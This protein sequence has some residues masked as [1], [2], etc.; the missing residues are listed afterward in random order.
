MV[1]R[2][3][4]GSVGALVL[5]AGCSWQRFDEVSERTPVELLERPRELNAGFGHAVAAAAVG[6]RVLAL[7]GGVPLV[8]RAATYELGYDERPGVQSVAST[9][10]DSRGDRACFFANSPAGLAKV[11]LRGEDQERCF[12]LG[13]GREGNQRGVVMRCG[14][15][16]FVHPVPDAVTAAIDEVFEGAKVPPEVSLAADRGEEPALLAASPSVGTAWFYAPLENEFH[17]LPGGSP[18]SEYGR[19][20]AVVRI[21]G[22]FVLAVGDP[23]AREVRL[24]RW[25]GGDAVESLGCLSGPAGFGRALTAGRLDDDDLDDLAIADKQRVRVLS[26]AA[27][28]GAAVVD[29]DEDCVEDL[30]PAESELFRVE[31]SESSHARDCAE[32]DFGAAVAVADLDG[33]GSGE[34][35]VGAPAMTA[36]GEAGAGAVL[37]FQPSSGGARLVDTRVATASEANGRFGATLAPV[38]QR[39]RDVLLVGVPG[40]GKAALVYCSG[41]Y[42]GDSP[43]CQ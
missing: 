40:G 4:L 14:S 23:K 16:S 3:L 8:S 35:V 43:R 9:L 19:G 18:G 17:E 1:R 30:L 5:L 20:V 33:D 26:G 7:V 10:C 2:A 32:A 34:L 25:L 27:L 11:R 13:L 15:V 38:P 31:C 36:R 21:S 39:G 6:E 37:V 12:A 29:P 22:G 42:T 28:E 41:L 24:H